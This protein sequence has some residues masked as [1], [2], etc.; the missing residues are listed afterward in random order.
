MHIPRPAKLLF[1]IDDGWDQLLIK[2]GHAVPEWTKLVIERMLACGTGA[3]GVH[4]YCCA[5]PACSHTKYFCQSCKSKGCSACGMKATEQWIAEQQHILPDC[6]WQHITFTMPDKLWP[7]FTNNWPLLNQLFAC[8]ANT[9]LKWAK[10]LGIEIGLFVAL[11]TYGRQLN[12]H[13]HIHLSV[14]RG[15]LCLKHGIWRPIFFKKKIVERYWRQAIITLLR[16]NYATLNLPMTGFEH[17]RD[18]REW[19]QFIEAQYQR[20]WKIH[21]AKKNSK[22]PPKRQLSWPLPETTADSRFKITSLHRGAVVHHYFDHRTGRHRTQR[23]SQ[24]EMLW[25]YISHIQ[26]RHFK[27]VR[28]Y[29]FLTYRKRGALL[30]KVYEAQGMIVKAKPQKPGFASLMKQFTNVDPYQCVLCGSRMVFNC[31]EAGLRAEALLDMRRQQFKT[32][33]WLQQA[34]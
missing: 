20:R 32:E 8:A 22:P 21:F 17:I 19:C 7:A 23:L 15:G 3:M 24:E 12:Q 14:T 10:K 11:H 26:S 1:Q 5:S 33:R 13:P 6:E 34:A 30:P 29:G 9:L 18:Y 27:M 4:R 28:Y 16:E 2:N 31:A 25:R